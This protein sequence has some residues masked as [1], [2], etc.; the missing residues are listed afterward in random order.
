MGPRDVSHIIS[1][2]YF[3]I[4]QCL[5]PPDIKHAS[6]ENVDDD[7]PIILD[8]FDNTYICMYIQSARFPLELH[9]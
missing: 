8:V 3:R 2:H 1:I 4:I 6:Y 5:D 7:D 9:R